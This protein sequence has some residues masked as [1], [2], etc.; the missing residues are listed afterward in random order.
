MLYVCPTP[1]GNLRD[2]TQRVLDVLAECDLVAC[3]DTR[4]TGN[5][6]RH[7]G[8][9]K[10][11]VSFFEHNEVRRVGQLI[12]ALRQGKVVALVSDAGTPALSDPGYTL[13]RACLDEDLPL[14][15]LPG[16]SALLVALVASGLPTDRFTF[17]GFVPRGRAERVMAFF[18]TAAACGGTL[19]AFESP[20]RIGST[21]AVLAARWPERRAAIC[22]ELTKLHEEI[23]RGSLAQLASRVSGPLRGEIVL[24]LEAEAPPARGATAHHEEGSGQVLDAALRRLLSRE[25]GAREAAGFLAEVTGRPERKLYSRA[26]DLQRRGPGE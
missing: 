1:I 24:V 8:L 26:L 7:F 15:V 25:W 6:L 16:P 14:T 2:I 17:L 12:A 19:V 21:L 4:R 3:E 22:R 5:L 9:R 20:R 18:Q 11:L 23:Q 10:E 13:V